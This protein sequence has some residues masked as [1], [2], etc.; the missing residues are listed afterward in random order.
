MKVLVIGGSRGVG[1]DIVNHF[2]GDSISR[3]ATDPGFNIRKD[4]D[5]TTIANVSLDYDI[6]VNHAYSGD[7]SQT[8][9]LL[10]LFEVWQESKHEGYLINSGSDASKLYR[11]KAKKD[12]MY[13]VLK[14]SQNTLSH[15]ISRNIQEGN[16]PM[17]YTNII[18]GMLDTEKARA[19]PHYKNGVRGEDIC[20]VIELLYNLPTDCLIPEFV[21]EA[22]DPE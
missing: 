8:L 5:R 19:R 1:L 11:M 17:R 3:N 21:M 12:P 18:Y 9:M 20:K 4:E 15:V 22:R 2:N 13:A 14:E 16:V 10:N 7:F 6:V